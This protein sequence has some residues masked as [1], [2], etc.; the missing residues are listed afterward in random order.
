ML[1]QFLS[2]HWAYLLIFFLGFFI[3]GGSQMVYTIFIDVNVFKHELNVTEE[4][5]LLR[6]E[7]VLSL[8]YHI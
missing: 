6:N 2:L 8:F 4:G 3:R 5:T 1:A 7:N